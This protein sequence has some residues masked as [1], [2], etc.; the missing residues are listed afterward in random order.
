MAGALRLI[1]PPMQYRMPEFERRR[2]VGRQKRGGAS[3]KAK[4]L[5]EKNTTKPLKISPNYLDCRKKGQIDYT[6]RRQT[7]MCI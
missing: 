5:S 4:P 7:N 6:E 3:Q 1:G 2:E